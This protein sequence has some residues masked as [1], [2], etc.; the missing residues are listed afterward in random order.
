MQ[1]LTE[2]IKSLYRH[3]MQLQNKS[4]VF[5]STNVVPEINLKILFFDQVKK[6]IMY[7]SN[8]QKAYG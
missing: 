3:L 4:G 7:L 5:N 6:Y 1:V 2:K 8:M